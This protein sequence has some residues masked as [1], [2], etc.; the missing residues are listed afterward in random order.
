MQRSGLNE[1][2][3]RILLLDLTFLFLSLFRGAQFL[4]FQ[5]G[6]AESDLDSSPISYPHVRCNRFLHRIIW[7]LLCALSYPVLYLSKV[8][9]HNLSARTNF[10]AKAHSQQR[11]SQA[12]EVRLRQAFLGL[13][14]FS[15]NNTASPSWHMTT[16]VFAHLLPCTCARNQGTPCPQKKSFTQARYHNLHDL[17][18][19]TMNLRRKCNPCRI[20]HFFLRQRVCVYAFW[21]L[22]RA[23]GIQGW[24]KGS[25]SALGDGF[26][27]QR[28]APHDPFLTH[29]HF[30]ACQ[31]LCKYSMSQGSTEESRVKLGWTTQP[32]GLALC[33]D[34]GGTCARKNVHF[35]KSGKVDWQT[36]TRTEIGS[37]ASA[38]GQGMD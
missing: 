29:L 13:E 22:L 19:A 20:T 25:P 15:S 3:F 14:G 11:N 2:F 5:I 33:A 34:W 21:S 35:L 1:D 23:R 37:S 31:I 24:S 8:L 9:N 18:C 26:M 7:V 30:S 36:P 4:S 38:L 10:A 16:F 27:G 28:S 32:V 17:L 6:N 12:K